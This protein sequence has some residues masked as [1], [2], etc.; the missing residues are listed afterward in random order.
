MYAQALDYRANRMAWVEPEQAV[1][2]G[3]DG[4]VL[5]I[6]LGESRS[7]GADKRGSATA[8]QCK[9]V[10][11]R[12]GR[13]AMDAEVFRSANGLV[14]VVQDDLFR[15]GDRFYLSSNGRVVPCLVTKAR[16]GS[17]SSDSRSTQVLYLR[18]P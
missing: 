6:L 7:R 5:G 10:H 18:L 11:D 9:A 8:M 13:Y 1:R 4:R 15:A 17:R 12:D 14:A 3:I 2:D 16:P